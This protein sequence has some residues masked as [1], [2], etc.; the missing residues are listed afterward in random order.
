[1]NP[2]IALPTA[3]IAAEVLCASRSASV[4]Q[5]STITKRVVVVAAL[6][7]VVHL[8]ALVFGANLRERGAGGLLEGVGLAGLD[9]KLDSQ[10]DRHRGYLGAE[11]ARSRSASSDGR[12]SGSGHVIATKRPCTPRQAG[13]DRLGI[14]SVSSLAAR[15]DGVMIGGPGPRIRNQD[16]RVAGAPARGRHRIRRQGASK[17]MAEQKLKGSIPTGGLEGMAVLVT[18]GG[19]GIGAACA[20]RLAADGAAVTICGADRGEARRRGQEDRRGRRPR[21]Q[22]PVDRRRRHQRGRT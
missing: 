13:H 8:A 20:A 4:A 1:M 18:G 12:R 17:D 19:T 15:A 10:S 14:R 3:P 11:T 9:G 21:R 22:R 6:E 7:Q 2:P 16:L 5:L